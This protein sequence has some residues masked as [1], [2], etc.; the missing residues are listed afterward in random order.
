MC[1]HLAYLGP[2]AP[3]RPALFDAPHSL[4]AQAA[5]ARLMVVATHNPDGWGVAWYPEPGR[6][7]RSRRST[8]PLGITDAA[9]FDGV[10]AAA[11]VAAVRLASPGTSLDERNN[12]P[13]VAGALAFSLNGFV[14]V[15][16]RERRLRAA[17]TA[18]ESAPPPGDA[19]SHLL[20]T[21][22][23]R[24]VADGAT[25]AEALRTVHA[26]V[27][28]DETM[29]VNLLLTDGRSVAATTWRHTLFHRS[30]AD[31]TTLA[32]EP[33]DHDPGWTPFPDRALVEVHPGACSVS[34]L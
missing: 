23:R 6:A 34:D 28:P 3:L 1:R 25:P 8:A 21:L 13:L 24:A 2:A 4:Q 15:G 27:D 14:F 9:T 11:F 30:T 12:A 10:A 16:D 26:A 18:D 32:S 19:D 33:L 29:R 31:A 7:P 20:F 5:D 22:A 17:A